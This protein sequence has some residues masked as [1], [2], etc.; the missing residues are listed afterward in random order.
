MVYYTSTS[1]SSASSLDTMPSNEAASLGSVMPYLQVIMDFDKTITTDDT[2]NTLAQVAIVIKAQHARTESSE[3]KQSPAKIPIEQNWKACQESYMIDYK[4]HIADYLPK[5]GER[6]SLMEEIQFER[7]LRGVEERSI[8]RVGRYGIFK[9]I[10]AEMFHRHAFENFKEVEFQRNQKQQSEDRDGGEIQKPGNGIFI[11]E[12][13]REFVDILGDGRNR[14]GVV[15]VNWS[16]HWIRG[17][18][19][20][21]LGE[22]KTS[23]EA[24]ILAN[25]IDPNTGDVLGPR[26]KHVSRLVSSFFG[27]TIFIALNMSPEKETAV[28]QMLEPRSPK[29]SDQPRQSIRLESDGR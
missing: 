5:P 18:L 23:S 20:W 28:N 13:F 8:D 25:E 10:T 26:W 22:G 14:W 12:G 3:S 1:R 29:N 11:R 21:A 2:I 4:K 19:E 9:G 6:K 24:M 27:V 15:S 7:S 17:S 16:S